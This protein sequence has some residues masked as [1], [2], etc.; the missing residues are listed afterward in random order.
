MAAAEV[1][2]ITRDLEQKAVTWADRA[3]AVKITNQAGYVGACEEVKA[4]K[5]LREEAEIHHRPMIDAAHKAHQ[6]ALAGLKKIDAPLAEAERIYKGLI[7]DYVAQQERIRL[8]K[9]RS[10]R[11]EADRLAAEQREREIE[12]AEAQG[13]TAEEVRSIVEAPL[14]ATAPVISAP[15][16]QAVA[17]VSKPR[18]NWKA[19]VTS[20]A[21][22]IAFVAANPRFEELLAPNETAL[23]G[24]ARAMK[25]T[26]N[27]DGVESYNE[28][29]I[30]VRR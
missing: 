23:N 12:E 20:R 4:V 5:A 22:L 29:V 2:D 26:M 8:E 28:A 7:G 13:A 9:E 11:I 16:V 24:L 18:E 10:A 27:I 21:K 25:A 1:I 19:R 15:R 30:S 6:A 3:R 17:G 14:P